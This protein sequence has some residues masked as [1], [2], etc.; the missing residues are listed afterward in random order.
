M[1]GSKVVPFQQGADFLHA[2][3]LKQ[4]RNGNYLDALDLLRRA[5]T[6]A[7]ADADCWLDMAAVYADMHCY[8]DSRAMTIRHILHREM[9]ADAYWQL[10][11]YDMELGALPEAEKAYGQYLQW[12][13]EGD[14]VDEAREE[15]SDIQLAYSVWRQIDRH[16]RRKVRQLRAVRRHQVER[17]FAGADRIFAK[18]LARTPSDAQLRVNRAMNC[19]MQGDAAAARREIDLAAQHIVEYPAAIIILA[20]QVY[21]RLDCVDEADRLLAQLDRHE[22]SA[23]DWQMLMALQAELQ[24]DEEAYAS[25]WEAL[26]QRPYDRPLLH[27]MAATAFRLG[28]KA[29]VVAGYWLRLLRMDPEDDVALHYLQKLRRG[30]LNQEQLYDAYALPNS[31]RLRRGNRLLEMLSMPK[32]QMSDVWQNVSDRRTL[33]WAIHSEAPA[34]VEPAIRV[35]AA[36]D[37]PESMGYVAEFVARTRLDLDIRLS[38]AQALQQSRHDL[39]P[40]LTA[41]MQ[42]Q[43]IPSYQEAL[44]YLPVAHRQMVRMAQQILEQDYDLQADIALAMQCVHYLQC[45]EDDF[46]RMRDLRCAAAALALTELRAANRDVSEQDVAWKFG[47]SVRKLKYYADALAKLIPAEP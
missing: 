30:E 28:R 38:A 35:L 43:M 26:K 29:S 47:C 6:Q 42:M 1:T 15:L 45:H 25:G 2:R 37:T 24:R 14:K 16:T 18:E 7:P 5:Q 36:I 32:A 17:D 19:C 40:G 13:R 39:W 21:C 11:K 9:D 20:A 10:A 12:V 27:L 3:G 34:L 46:D 23:Q 33:H 4:K 8:G 22:M 31:E 41:Y 44:D